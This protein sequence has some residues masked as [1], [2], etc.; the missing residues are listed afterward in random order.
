MNWLL[1][2]K[3]KFDAKLLAQGVHTLNE[4]HRELLQS[5]SRED[6]RMLSLAELSTRMAI[7]D[8]AR[9]LLLK[10]KPLKKEIL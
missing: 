6:E 2:I 1:P 8:G 9:N 5:T 3:R 7:I 4:I 10:Y